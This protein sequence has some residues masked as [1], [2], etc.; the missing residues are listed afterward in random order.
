M[1][2]VIALI[3]GL[4][5]GLGLILSSMVDPA[6]VRG[7]LDFAGDWNPA[8]MFVL[9]GAVMVSFIAWRIRLRRT[10]SYL[11]AEL[12]NPPSSGVDRNLVIGAVLF[13]IGWGL[14]G[15]CPGPAIT[16]IPF[17]VTEV[18]IFVIAMLGGMFA[19]NFIERKN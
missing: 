12:P 7:F 19:Y 2:I 13:G 9:G 3:S 17:G 8:L 11:G 1:R 14:V 16:A 18:Y 5:F 6:V 10:T 15:I 4:L